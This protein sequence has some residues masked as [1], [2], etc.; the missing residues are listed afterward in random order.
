MPDT[1]LVAGMVCAAACSADVAAG[2]M[3]EA[4]RRSLEES[5]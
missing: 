4:A 1:A 2:Y 3:S 5:M